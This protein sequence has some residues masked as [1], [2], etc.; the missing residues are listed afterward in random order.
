MKSKISTSTTEANNTEFYE[1]G[2]KTTG[3][4]EKLGKEKVRK[5]KIGRNDK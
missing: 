4:E 5:G 1:T 3:Y 2:T